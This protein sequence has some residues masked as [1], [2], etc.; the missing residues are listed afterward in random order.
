VK[1]NA[2]PDQLR[3]D[4][5]TV[6]TLTASADTGSLFTGWSGACSGNTNCVV[7]MDMAKSVIV[8]F[9]LEQ[10]ELSVALTGAGSGSVASDP[11]G[12]SCGNDCFETL[13]YGTILTFTATADPAGCSGAGICMVTIDEAKNVTVTFDL[14]VVIYTGFTYHSCRNL[15]FEEAEDHQN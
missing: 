5:G 12:I 14:E 4:Y 2:D 13:D 1:G 8:I 6:V 10:Y 7:T 11:A 9:T 15:S 3:Y